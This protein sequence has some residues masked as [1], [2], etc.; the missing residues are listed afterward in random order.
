MSFLHLVL[1]PVSYDSRVLKE[2]GSILALWPGVPLEIAA[3]HEHGTPEEE[4]M[5]GR[6][7]RRWR[8]T[9]RSLPRNLLSQLIKYGEWYLRVSRY[10]GNKSL[11]II[12]C[13]DLEPLPVAVALKRKTGAKL[14]Y[15]AHELET[16][17]FAESEKGVM[18]SIRQWLL[19]RQEHR[20][21][22]HVDRIITV[23]PSIRAWYQKKYPQKR[24]HLI[25][26]IP[27]STGS[28]VSTVP[29]RAAL[30]VPDDVLLFLYLG[31]LTRGRGIE[32]ILDAFSRAEVVHHVL[33][34]G[35]G[36]LAESVKQAAQSCRRIH[37]RNPV[38]PSDVVATTA[39]A[40][41]GLCLIDDTCLSKRFC[42]PNKLFE[43]LVAGLPVVVS[44]LPDQAD[45]VRRY[46]AGWIVTPSGENITRLLLRLDIKNTRGVREGLSSR[47]ADL[48]WENE[49]KTLLD[50]YQKELKS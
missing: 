4:D 30:G 28:A 29:L 39:G 34:M 18:L 43:C 48:R 7:V 14:I 40:D 27:A 31:G 42:L 44:D 41:V 16:E 22:P 47:V 49:A 33:F 10:Y 45:L 5:G 50:I 23:S 3:L 1:N 38:P 46:K 37:H 35:N 15:D 25:R 36:P 24:V 6:Q 12:H 11:K 21:I 19:R 2:T 20:L 8:L 9:T 32:A 26:N 17:N 13:H